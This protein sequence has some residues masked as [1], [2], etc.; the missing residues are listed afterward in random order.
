M[1]RR[2]IGTGPDRPFAAVLCDGKEAE[3]AEA[4]A[5]EE[6]LPGWK[7]VLT[8]DSAEAYYWNE[9]TNA[10]SWD[11]PIV[12]PP[13]LSAISAPEFTAD[14]EAAVAE[15]EG[16]TEHPAA[17]VAAAWGCLKEALQAPGHG[18]T[19]L[20]AYL[21]CRLDDWRAGGLSNEFIS[22]RLVEMAEATRS[23][24][25]PA[26]ESLPSAASEEPVD[27]KSAPVS[28]TS[29]ESAANDDVAP[30]CTSSEQ[31]ADSGVA[32]YVASHPSA[33]AIIMEKSS[34]LIYSST[35]VTFSAKQL[36]HEFKNN[37]KLEV[38]ILGDNYYMISFTSDDLAKKGVET[39]ATVAGAIDAAAVGWVTSQSG[40]WLRFV[41][42]SDLK[43]SLF[44][45]PAE[46]FTETPGVLARAAVLTTTKRKAK[47]A[48]TDLI[49]KWKSVRSD[50][51][52]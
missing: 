42:L 31:E 50:S 10:V 3:A 19:R 4:E 14:F 35:G 52:D 48:E 17:A 18:G 1:G 28:K 37:G 15:L 25:F 23:S 32:E 21:E 43:Q 27:D 44:D 13:S 46:S 34:V 47:S 49:Q 20:A 33:P 51:D 8:E 22:M 7:R 38:R 36:A 9:S 6:L 45:L 41:Q 16:S 40:Y 2:P 30:S 12:S 11:A 26:S 24:M 5:K 29:P 39:M